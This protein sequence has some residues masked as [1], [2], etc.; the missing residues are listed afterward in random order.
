[1][2]TIADFD[3]VRVNDVVNTERQS[4]RVTRWLL[5]GILLLALVLRLWGASFGLPYMYHADE[6]DKIAKASSIIQTGDLNPHYFRK[7]SLSI[8]LLTI[9]YVPYYLMGHA[10]GLF[11]SPNDLAPP[12]MIA[13]GVG[14]T[15]LIATVLIG[16]G[17]SIFFGVLGVWL[18]YKVGRRLTPRPDLGLI[19][20]LLL[21][22]SPTQVVNSRLIAPESLLVVCLIL[23]LWG[24]LLILQEDRTRHYVL[25]GLA[26]GLT[27]SAKYN[28]V[29]VVLVLIAA[30]LLRHGLAGL[31]DK[32]LYLA[33]IISGVAFLV[34]TPYALLD[35]DKF[36]ADVAD[37]AQDYATGHFGMEG[38]TFTWYTTYL[39]QFEGVVTITAI[40]A[41][42]WGVARHTK[43]RLSETM[44]LAIFPIV[45]FVFLNLY[46]VRND[47]LVVPLIPFLC[48]LSARFFFD[49][50]EV[51]RTRITHDRL[52]HG[53]IA[54]A[55]ALMVVV[56][57]TQNLVISSRLVK[58]DSRETARIWI[59][60]HLPAGSKIAV[61][62]Y[63]PFID[64]QRFSVQGFLRMIDHPV[65]W[66]ADKGFK[67]IVVSEGMFGRFFLE[68]ERYPSEVT[69]YKALFE[70]LEPVQEF[71]DADYDIRVYRIRDQ[72]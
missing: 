16:R 55:I 7:P 13:M 28:G 70:A 46:V 32:R 54:S 5:P 66:Y 24:S 59:A 60:Q 64:P 25:A 61:E 57:L 19:A 45:Y 62:S 44:V 34:T 35:S 27:A 43:T 9:G 41:V 38:N 8:Y 11:Q 4:S 52:R 2:P 1:M 14:R 12:T 17:I 53:L 56:P 20:A 23:A 15:P 39:L 51:A 69:Q 3:P 72:S 42:I 30:H 26:V 36:A 10:L 47:R 67:Y 6:P 37:Q 48:V 68:P 22:I 71:N 33:L 65:V 63:A 29:L 40:A 58:T 50:L 49:L 18:V 31:K 21:A